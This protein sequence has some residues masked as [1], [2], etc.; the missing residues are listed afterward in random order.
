MSNLKIMIVALIAVAVLFLPVVALAEEGVVIE[1]EGVSAILNGNLVQARDMAISDALRRA[2]EQVVGTLVDSRTDTK[3]YQLIQDTIRVKST[4]YVSKY[5]VLSTKSEDGMYTAVVRATVK[6]D[7][8]KQE[9]DALKLT[10]ISAGKPRVMVIISEQGGNGSLVAEP[11]IIRILLAN[12]FPVVDRN[13]VYTSKNRELITQAVAGSDEASTRLA[14]DYNAEILVVGKATSES[15]GNYEGLISCQAS[16][17]IRAVRA[18][19]GQTMAANSLSEKGVDLAEGAAFRKALLKASGRMA[20]Y[21]KGQLGKQLT[22]A[23]RSVRIS[24]NGI[25]YSQL[26]L[27]QRHLKET[28]SVTNVFLRDFSAGNARIDVDTGLLATQLADQMMSWMDLPLEV[29]G[30]ADGKIDLKKK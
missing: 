12:G 6:K 8:V 22:E 7:A 3:N 19:T 2:V 27:L 11:E 5:D 21:L 4:G 30:L 23:N 14:S 20:E 18:S 26:Q 16:L 13:Q 25:S 1:V 15:L 9:V 28:P 17:E 24:V 29:V 10:I